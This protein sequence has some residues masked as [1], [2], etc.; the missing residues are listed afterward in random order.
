ML[1]TR[2]TLISCLLGIIGLLTACSGASPREQALEV[3]V[4]ALQNQVAQAQT[5]SAPMISP[6][7]A[8][9]TGR[10]WRKQ[11]IGI[12][13][14]PM[15]DGWNLNGEE[16]AFSTCKPP[17]PCASDEEEYDVTMWW[18]QDEDKSKKTLEQLLLFGKV[19]GYDPEGVPIYVILD[20]LVAAEIEGEGE[21]LSLVNCRVNGNPKVD[22]E[23]HTVLFSSK[24]F[25][26]PVRAWRANHLTGH[27]EEIPVDGLFCVDDSTA[28]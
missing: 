6:T 15:P 19:V 7:P 13:A 25:N 9:A 2:C 3:T 11:L 12:T 20:V 17:T 24:N 8:P 4:V 21:Y 5:S 28:N 26:L 18:R 14:P 10:D 16:T 27:F 23:I 22:N 1:R